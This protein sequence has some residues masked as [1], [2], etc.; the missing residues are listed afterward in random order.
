MNED[1]LLRQMRAVASKGVL[2][3]STLT[4]GGGEHVA[5][6]PGDAEGE[7]NGGDIEYM[8]SLS[9]VGKLLQT[10]VAAPHG[11]PSMACGVKHRISPQLWSAWGKLSGATYAGGDIPFCEV[12]GMMLFDFIKANP[13]YAQVFNE[14][15]NFLTISEIK[16]IT[17]SYD[18]SVYNGKT[19][20]DVG[21]GLGETAAM[22]KA[23]YPE[24][25]MLCFD[26]PEVIESIR[27]SNKPNGVEFVK[28]DFFDPSTVPTCDLAFLKH[29]FHDWS[30]ED[31]SKILRSLHSAL[32][33]HAKLMVV[34]CVLPGPGEDICSPLNT[35]RLQYNCYMA[36]FGG[37]ERTLAEWKILFSGNG[38]SLEE[39]A[40]DASGG[41]LC[42]LITVVKEKP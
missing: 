24:I 22:L 9:P 30:D 2:M 1:L 28:G 7:N 41:P 26:L 23:K 20:C 42:C 25:N 4:D 36:I 12:T 19:I 35:E 21:G 8:Y 3:E 17:Q 33:P 32:P 37:K 5:G 16:G 27:E 13:A 29:I 10:G 31:S 11:I 40:M 38:W 18:W 15:M 14:F 34:N 6:G 39:V